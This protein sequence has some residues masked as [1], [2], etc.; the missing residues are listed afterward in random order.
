VKYP[1]FLTIL[2]NNGLAAVVSDNVVS[3]I[4]DIL[5]RFSAPRTITSLQQDIPADEWVSFLHRPQHASAPQ[6]VPILRPLM[7]QAAHLAAFPE[8]NALI[9][10]DRFANVQRIV[11]IIEQL[12]RPSA[13]NE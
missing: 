10:V 8:Q 2:R 1:V 3:I 9:I 6:L 13:R 7:P 11:Q 5:V 4:P 12:D